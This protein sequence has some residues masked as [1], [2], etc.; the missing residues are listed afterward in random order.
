MKIEI[1][2]NDILGD[3]N[4]AETLQDS[5]RRQVVESLTASVKK[6]IQDKIDVAVS[7]TISACLGEYVKEQIPTL[8]ADLMS[9]EYTPIGRYGDKG[10]PT[11][12]RGELIKAI[13]ENMVYK[14]VNY[15]SDKNPFTKAVDEVIEQNIQ[16]FKADFS[17][18][19]DAQFT[20]SAMQYAQDSLKKKLGIA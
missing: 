7:Q 9:A 5:V 12:F 16:L 2:L 13:T 1:D 20:A 8:V 11:T 18:Q 14:K 10:T 19:V 6:G 15:S 17:K 3:E 4:G